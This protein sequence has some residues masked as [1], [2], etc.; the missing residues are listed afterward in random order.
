MALVTSAVIGF[1]Q[2]DGT[3]R[4]LIIFAALAYIFGVQLPTITINIPLNNKLQALD[5]GAMNE[6]TQKM[7]RKE[8]EP[9]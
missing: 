2:L 3:G 1:G 7:A 8:F 5:V 4:L 9:R 6:A